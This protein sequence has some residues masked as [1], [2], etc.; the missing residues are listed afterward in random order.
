VAV[1]DRVVIK[2]G[3]REI[4]RAALRARRGGP[5]V[6]KVGRV[7]ARRKEKV[8]TVARKRA[9]SAAASV[10]QRCKIAMSRVS[11]RGRMRRAKALTRR[12]TALLRR[13]RPA[14]AV[15]PK[16]GTQ[17]KQVAAARVGAT[18]VVRADFTDGRGSPAVGFAV[19]KEM[20]KC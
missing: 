20:C 9:R 16:R 15:R 12:A 3:L 10:Q 6:R 1:A 2:A 18:R 19:N 8:E 17:A 4:R 11:S 14:A 13:A 5:R 7:V